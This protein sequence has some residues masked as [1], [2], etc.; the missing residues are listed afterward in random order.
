MAENFVGF[1][2]AAPDGEKLPPEVRREV[3]FIAPT[4]VSNGSIVEDKI[5]T[6]AVTAPKIAD[7]A[8]GPTKLAPGAV[9]SGQ[10][11]SSAVTTGKLAPGA[12]THEKA[13]TGVMKTFDANGDPIA[14]RMVP[15]T[16]ATYAGITPDPNTFYAVY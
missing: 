2:D 13:G 3:A 12:V 6:A 14:A 9:G 8:V 10:L 5:G 4:T 7:G 15:I 16:A 11:A 1:D